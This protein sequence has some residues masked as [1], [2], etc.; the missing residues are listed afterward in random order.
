MIVYRNK[1]LLREHAGCSHPIPVPSPRH[2]GHSAI[3]QRTPRGIEPAIFLCAECGLRHVSAGNED[4]YD[5]A[6]STSRIYTE[7]DDKSLSG[8][9]KT[10]HLWPG[11][12]RP[13]GRVRTE[14]VFTL[15][16]VFP[17]SRFWCA[18][19]W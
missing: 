16:R 15:P 19:S 11:Q 4:P 3:L 18:S 7:C 10:G 9:L 6:C 12:N 1:V 8:H 13:V 14:I 17:A 2:I 5:V